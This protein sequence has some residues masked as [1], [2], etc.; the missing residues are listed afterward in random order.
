M[1]TKVRT[2]I[3]AALRASRSVPSGELDERPFGA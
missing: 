3:G 1:E 2:A